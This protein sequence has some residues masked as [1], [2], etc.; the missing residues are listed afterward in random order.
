VDQPVPPENVERQVSAEAIP[1]RERAAAHNGISWARQAENRLAESA[2]STNRR[3]RAKPAS[4]AR[5]VVPF[6]SET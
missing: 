4:S 1:C 5:R 6:W 2:A 3:L